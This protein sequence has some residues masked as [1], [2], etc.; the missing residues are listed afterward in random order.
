MEP[1]ADTACS[2]PFLL[3]LE[4]SSDQ[5]LAYHQTV[6]LAGNALDVVV[7]QEKQSIVV[8]TDNVHVP[9]SVKHVRTESMPPGNS[10]VSFELVYNNDLDGQDETQRDLS[11]K[12]SDL[13]SPI[14][15]QSLSPAFGTSLSPQLIRQPNVKATYS[16]LGEFL[17]GLENSRKNRNVAEAA[18]EPNAGRGTAC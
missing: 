15:R 11:W 10:V 16:V 17:Y 12:P 18:E 3:S 9:G 4:W 7:F 14:A 13:I 2:L 1:C 6:E 8:S 5:R